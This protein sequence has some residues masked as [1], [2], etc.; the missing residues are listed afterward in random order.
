[1]PYEAGPNP[2]PF[3]DRFNSLPNQDIF[4]STAGGVVKTEQVQI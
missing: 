3:K 4:A 1:M 2:Q